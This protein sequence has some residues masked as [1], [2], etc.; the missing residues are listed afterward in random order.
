M[1]QQKQ[2]CHAGVLYPNLA[3][4]ELGDERPRTESYADNHYLAICYLP[5]GLDYPS[6]LLV[7]NGTPRDLGMSLRRQSV[8]LSPVRDSFR[9]HRS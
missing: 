2:A 3:S 1:R 9:G 5:L 6:T 8:L 4:A 7:T